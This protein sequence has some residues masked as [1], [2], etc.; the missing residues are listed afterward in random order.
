MKDQLQSNKVVVL[1]EA[2]FVRSLTMFRPDERAALLARMIE[3]V[4]GCA[5]N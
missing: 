1:T 4:K 3:A 5:T 2:E